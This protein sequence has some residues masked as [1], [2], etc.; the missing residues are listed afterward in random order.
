MH[1]YFSN[2]FK[3]RAFVLNDCWYI[4]IWGIIFV[5]PLVRRDVELVG[6]DVEPRREIDV[7]V[8]FFNGDTSGV[9]FRGEKEGEF[10]LGR[11]ALPAVYV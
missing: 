6:A 4:D 3:S 11:R 9:N 8:P 2:S 7:N 1:I 10:G 5:L